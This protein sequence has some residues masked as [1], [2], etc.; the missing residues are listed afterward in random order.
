MPCKEARERARTLLSEE[1]TSRRTL[2]QVL[3]EYVGSRHLQPATAADYEALLRRH[4]AAWLNRPVDTLTTSM[5]VE[6]YRAIEMRSQADKWGRIMR[7]LLRFAA[8]SG[9]CPAVPVTA[10]LRIPATRR[11]RTVLRPYEIGPWWQ[12]TAALRQRQTRDILRFLLLTGFRKS[13]ALALRWEHI[14]LG[15]LPTSKN[16]DPRVL[17]FGREAWAIIEA[18][19]KDGGRVFHKVKCFR[20]ALKRLGPWCAHDLRR[21]YATVAE[22]LDL[23]MLTIKRLLGHRTAESDVTAGY[24]VPDRERLKAAAQ[25]VEDEILRL[26]ETGDHR[27]DGVRVANDLVFQAKPMT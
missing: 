6:R 23:S 5:M 25:S 22:S 1:W 9:Y 10:G 16:G 2:Q 26:V 15:V 24:I 3:M 11:R 12:G 19:P 4:A 14:D 8:L 27:P 7:A 20:S 17:V 18:Q 13:E 21:T